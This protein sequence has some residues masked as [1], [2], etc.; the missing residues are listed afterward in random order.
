MFSHTSERIVKENVKHGWRFDEKVTAQ[1]YKDLKK[2][3]D[4]YKD[5]DLDKEFQI[6]LG[7]LIY[8]F[9]LHDHG[10]PLFD[11]FW[12]ADID[13]R[14][15]AMDYLLWGKYPEGIK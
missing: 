2:L 9:Q 12:Q 4:E 10:F 7:R 8:L 11:W 1:N 14:M 15:K 3:F 6:R 13:S 5:K